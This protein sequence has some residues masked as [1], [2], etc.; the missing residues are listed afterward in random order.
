MYLTPLQTLGGSLAQLLDGLMVWP[1]WLAI[2][3]LLLAIWVVWRRT[4]DPADPAGSFRLATDTG[5]ASVSLSGAYYVAL[6]VVVVA[7]LTWP[8][9]VEHPLFGAAHVLLVGVA[10]L[11]EKREAS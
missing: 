1:R 4:Q 3:V 8:L 5:T 7:A 9:P 2:P 10:W 11:L 6:L